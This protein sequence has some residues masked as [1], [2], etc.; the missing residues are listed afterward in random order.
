M[1]FFVKSGHIEMAFHN[2][3]EEVPSQLRDFV[4]CDHHSLIVWHSLIE[5]KGTHYKDGVN[6][7]VVLHRVNLSPNMGQG[8]WYFFLNL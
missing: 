5:T 6:C 1:H 7:C 3:Q 2:S 4:E 8:F